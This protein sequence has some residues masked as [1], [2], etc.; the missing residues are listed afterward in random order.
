MFQGVAPMIELYKGELKIALMFEDASLMTGKQKQRFD[1][2]EELTG[3]KKKKKGKTK[4]S[5]AGKINVHIKEGSDLPSSD[6]DGLSD[7]F[8]KWYTI[9]NL[10][11][12]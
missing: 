5:T 12:L 7:P 2:Q 11:S 3:K 1:Q 6:R 4:I 10:D 9:F 8:C